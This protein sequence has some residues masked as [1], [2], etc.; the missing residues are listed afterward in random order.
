MSRPASARVVRDQIVADPAN[1]FL[2]FHAK[3]DNAFFTRPGRLRVLVT[4]KRVGR[5]R[6][7]CRIRGS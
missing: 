4:A 1:L 7:I 6:M 2:I 3:P 5:R